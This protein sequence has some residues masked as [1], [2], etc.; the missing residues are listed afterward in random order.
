MK[1]GGKNPFTFIWLL[2]EIANH[3]LNKKQKIKAI[4]NFFKW[5]IGSRLVPG[6]VIFSWIENTKFIVSPGEH[7]LTQNIY[8]GLQEFHDMAYVLHVTQED[9]LF[10]DVGANVGSFTI[11]ACGARKAR[12]YCFE[13]VPQ[14]FIRLQENLNLNGLSGRVQAHNLGVADKNGELL[15][16]GDKNTGNHIVKNNHS[17][18][19]TLKVDVVSLDKFLTGANPTI[20][21]I[22]VEGFETLVIEGATQILQQPSVHSVIMEINGNGEKQGFDEG[23]LVETMRSFGYKPFI[24]DPF[25]RNLA[26]ID[27][28]N[29]QSGNTI[30]C[31]KQETI[32]QRLIH[33]PKVKINGLEI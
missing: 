26:E 19:R 5:Q 7:G 29:K 24:Y 11:L 27:G 33:S 13:P 17:D 32:E 25:T 15:F 18:S 31:K 20:I 8:W 12:G 23:K 2:N 30:F 14:T 10:V 3:P 6:K 21:K 4:L 22:D 28:A 1:N 9:D 16:T